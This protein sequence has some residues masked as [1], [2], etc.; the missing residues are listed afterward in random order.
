MEYRIDETTI[1]SDEILA[2]TRGESEE[3]FS[4]EARPKIVRPSTGVFAIVAMYK[5]QRMLAAEYGQTT[6]TQTVR[7]STGMLIGVEMAKSTGVRSGATRIR[8]RR[9]RSVRLSTGVHVGTATAKQ[10]EM[11]N[12]MAKAMPVMAKKYNMLVCF[13][14]AST[15]Y[16]LLSSQQRQSTGVHYGTEMFLG[17]Q[18]SPGVLT[19]SQKSQDMYF[20]KDMA[21]E[22][23]KMYFGTD[24]AKE[25]TKVYVKKVSSSTG[26]PFQAMYRGTDLAYFGQVS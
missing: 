5:Q 22:S 6:R 13:G 16:V 7:L 24:M 17:A 3:T 19:K 23:T 25:S 10:Q 12:G 9:H 20:G 8:A 2:K 26:V 15:K 11:S 4:G 1:L 18:C 21:K 14:L